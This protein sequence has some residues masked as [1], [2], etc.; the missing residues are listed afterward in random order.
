MVVAVTLVDVLL[1]HS[2]HADHADG[3]LP[4]RV[5]AVLVPVQD[6]Q[7]IVRRLQTVEARLDEILVDLY[8]HGGQEG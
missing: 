5:D 2:E 1:E 3:F 4:G 7:R 6:T 8:L